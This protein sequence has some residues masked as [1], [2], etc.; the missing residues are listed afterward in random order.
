[1]DEPSLIQQAQSGDVDAYNTLVLHHQ[2]L[3]QPI[4]QSENFAAETLSRG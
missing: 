2:D 3:Y 1:M 4:K